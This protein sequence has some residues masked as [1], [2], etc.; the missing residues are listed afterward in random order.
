MSTVSPVILVTGATGTQG[1]G[2]VRELL[3]V[4]HSTNPPTPIIIHAFVRDPSSAASQALLALD[5][6]AVKLFQGDFD[7]I[8]SLTKAAEGA[9]ATFITVQPVFTDLEAESRHGRNILIASLS[10]GVRHV[11]YSAVSGIDKRESF[12]NVEPG[13]WIDIYYASKGSVIAAVKSPPVAVPA[14]YAYTIIQPATFLTNFLPPS[15]AFMYP[16]LNKENSSITTAFR[17][18]LKHSYLDPDDIGRF[19]AH[20]ILA[21]PSEFR[22]KWANKTIPL[23]SVDF[24]LEEAV[25]A[26]TK[27][28]GDRKKVQINFLKSGEAGEVAKTNPLVASQ[29]FINENPISVDLEE[30]RSYGIPL[31]SVEAFFDRHKKEV[32]QALG[33]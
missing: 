18:G 30:V 5:P 9:T 17:P 28:V 27:S 21:S 20:S 7:D 16:D 6:K 19:V 4:S 31:G 24:S 12:K 10:A 29:L 2:V 25:A 13:S 14:D 15:Q 3:K 26:L 32:E 8:S 22:E 33:L 23:A 1:G 11:I